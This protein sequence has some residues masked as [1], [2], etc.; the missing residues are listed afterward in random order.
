MHK[1]SQINNDTIRYQINKSKV[2]SQQWKTVNKSLNELIDDS[3]NKNLKAK[4]SR[5]L[6][7]HSLNKVHKS[8]IPLRPIM[9]MINSPNHKLAKLLKPICRILRTSSLVPKKWI[10]WTHPT[11]SQ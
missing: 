9:S 7:V 11:V 6:F 4:R 5:L 3:V 2:P 10:I 1:M 8:N